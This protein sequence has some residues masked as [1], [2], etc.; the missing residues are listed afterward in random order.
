MD[1]THI[2]NKDLE[3]KEKVLRSRKIKPMVRCIYDK[4][5]PSICINYKLDYI[6]S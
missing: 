2:Y 5:L 3:L 4:D 6:F 1:L